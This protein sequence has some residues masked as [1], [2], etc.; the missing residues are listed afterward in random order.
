MNKY[1]VSYTLA[2]LLGG[3]TISNLDINVVKPNALIVNKSSALIDKNTRISHNQVR[4]Y[5]GEFVSVETPIAYVF[6]NRKYLFLSSRANPHHAHLVPE[7]EY[8][9]DFFTVR[10]YLSDLGKFS[11]NFE[12]SIHGKT[13]LVTG[14]LVWYQ[15]DPN[16][17]VTDPSQIEI[18]Q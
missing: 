12:N 15:G 16:I 17:I 14:T 4:N 7:G 11:E 10:I 18:I 8:I 2:L 6:N 1:L 3:C 5:I 13:V 9:D